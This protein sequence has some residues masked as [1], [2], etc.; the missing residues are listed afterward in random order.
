M[1][2]IYFIAILIFAFSCS[3][4]DS[5]VSQE[6]FEKTPAI[7]YDTTAIDSFGPGATSESVMAKINAVAIKREK[8]SLAAI[9][10]AEQEKLDKEKAKLEA[11]KTK[12]EKKEPKPDTQAEVSTNQ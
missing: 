8:D 5:V 1:K 3:K 6:N 10:K 7:T 2:Y 12:E 4:K 11:E 9:A